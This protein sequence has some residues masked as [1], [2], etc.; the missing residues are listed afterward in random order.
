MI[1]CGTN[2][3]MVGSSGGAEDGWKPSCASVGLIWAGVG[4]PP[5]GGGGGGAAIGATADGAGAA[6][7]FIATC[8]RGEG[9][10]GGRALAVGA[11]GGGGAAVV[12][13]SATAVLGVMSP[14]LVSMSPLSCGAGFSLSA[15]KVVP[16]TPV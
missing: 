11:G 5:D 14:V 2:W 15:S 12:P 6:V 3:P 8:C 16:K 9:C 13:A 7:S 4:M 10:A 1:G